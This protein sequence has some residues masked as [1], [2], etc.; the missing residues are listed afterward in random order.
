M[1]HDAGGETREPDRYALEQHG[2]A[3]YQFVLRQDQE[4]LKYPW[5]DSRDHVRALL[6]ANDITG[7]DDF[8]RQGIQTVHFGMSLHRRFAE[9]MA[10]EAG[11][12]L[13]D[14]DLPTTEALNDALLYIAEQFGDDGSRK[15]HLDRFLELTSQA[16]NEDYLEEEKHFTFVNAGEPD[17]QLALKLSSVHDRVSKYVRDHGLDGEDLLNSASDYR[18]RMDEAA[19][20]NT[21]FVVTHSQYAPP[22]ARQLADVAEDPTGYATVAVEILTVDHPKNDSAPALRATVKDTSTAIDIISWNDPEAVPEDGA[23]VLENVQ[24]GKHDGQVQLTIR[25]GVTEVKPI[26]RG[27]G[28]TEIAESDDSQESLSSSAETPA[29]SAVEADGGSTVPP[30]AEG[31]LADARRLVEVLQRRAKPLERGELF[32]SAADADDFPPDRAEAALEYAVEEKGLIME[33]GD[34][35]TPT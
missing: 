27:V 26:Q 24:I 28:Y 22:L 10:A 34:G 1:A 14:L 35:Y 3:Y 18:D 21:S 11:F 9:E 2:V 29:T 7:V 31:R 32:A 12:S 20:D 15:S 23:V 5:R 33:T 17:E 19:D 25:E 13:N 6:T 4:T 16:A 8:P 30:D